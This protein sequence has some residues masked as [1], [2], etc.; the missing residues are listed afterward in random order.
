MAGVSTSSGAGGAA[1]SSTG[2]GS[3]RATST[4]AA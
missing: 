2:W 4:L 1:G 3:A